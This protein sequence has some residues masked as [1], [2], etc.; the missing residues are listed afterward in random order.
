[1][2]TKQEQDGGPVKNKKFVPLIDFSG[3]IKTSIPGTKIDDNEYP[4]LINGRTRF[5]SVTPVKQPK[6]LSAGLPGG[7]YQGIY[8]AG[9]RLIAFIS[10]KAYFINIAAESNS[11]NLVHGFTAMDPDV[12]KIYAEAVPQ[13]YVTNHRA[14]V[15]DTTNIISRRYL[16]SFGFPSPVISIRYFIF[17]KL[18]VV[19]LF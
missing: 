4:L 19:F 13:A 6:N 8:T 5:S 16:S 7:N 18:L 9:S 15:N 2:L 12:D 11:F 14:T 3:G 10:G 1:M 17:G